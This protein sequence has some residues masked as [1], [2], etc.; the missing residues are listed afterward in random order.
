MGGG[1]I[2]LPP[3][4]SA[5][6]WGGKLPLMTP[7]LAALAGSVWG[8]ILMARKAGDG[9]T[10]LPFGTLL[11]PAAMVASSVGGGAGSRP[12]REWSTLR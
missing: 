11:A 1:D 9:K 12:T 8:G 4:C 7:L 3:R 5:S 10:A 6:S 2:K